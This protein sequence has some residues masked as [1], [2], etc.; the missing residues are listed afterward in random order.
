[1]TTAARADRR[2]TVLRTELRQAAGSRGTAAL[3][4]V[5]VVTTVLIGYVA[6]HSL[7]GLLDDG[8]APLTGVD[9]RM[10]DLS[11]AHLRVGMADVVTGSLPVLALLSGG[12]VVRA[13]YRGHLLRL[14]VGR[15]VSR[16]TIAASKVL[17]L[18]V[19]S[20]VAALL[21]TTAGL[22]TSVILADRAPAPWPTPSD[23]ATVLAVGALSWFVWALTGLLAAIAMRTSHAA[24]ALAVVWLFTSGVT[25]TLSSRDDAL[26]TLARLSPATAAHEILLGSSGL[27]HLALV[28]V[29]PLA[30][31]AACL[32]LMRGSAVD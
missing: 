18:A 20:V 7:L 26:G 28:L 8:G 4:L 2:T 12:L 32:G 31:G 19:V 3:L 16:T 24:V 30:L 15:G 17:T 23:V 14:L 10:A 27:S 29:T 6:V 21:T 1:M 13:H 22:T 5:A 9:E 11:P 25:S